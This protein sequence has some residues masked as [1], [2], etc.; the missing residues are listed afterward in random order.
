MTV[1]PKPWLQ[2]EAGSLG[3]RRVYYYDPDLLI[4]Y[5]QDEAQSGQW[6]MRV[7]ISYFRPFSIIGVYQLAQFDGYSISYGVVAVKMDIP[8]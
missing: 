4:V 7:E 5:N 2:F 8:L 6:T 3:G 1:N